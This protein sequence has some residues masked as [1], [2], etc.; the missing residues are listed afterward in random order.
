MKIPNLFGDILQ[1]I[2]KSGVEAVTEEGRSRIPFRVKLQLIGRRGHHRG[3]V[4]VD[5]R[6]KDHCIGHF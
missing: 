6:L 3:K 1:I 4:N 5:K 2:C